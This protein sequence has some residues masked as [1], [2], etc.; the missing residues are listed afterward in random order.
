MLP[1]APLNTMSNL[2]SHSEQLDP[3]GI[4]SRAS[5]VG[6]LLSIP[7]LRSFVI[8]IIAKENLPLLGGKLRQAALQT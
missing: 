5:F 6:Q 2:F 8:L 4:R 7:Y 1:D 3:K